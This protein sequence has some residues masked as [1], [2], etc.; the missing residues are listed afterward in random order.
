MCYKMLNNLAEVDTCSFFTLSDCAITRG[1]SIKYKKRNV[2]PPGMQFFSKRV[3]SVWNLLPNSI[4]TSRT[5]QSFKRCLAAHDLT[6][7]SRF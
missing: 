2:F 4:V 1:H 3:V 5:V 6:N 7:F